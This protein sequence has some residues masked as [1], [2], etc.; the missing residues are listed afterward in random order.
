[1]KLKRNIKN[2]DKFRE[3]IRSS[4]HLEPKNISNL[5]KLVKKKINRLKLTQN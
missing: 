3:I 5:I 1:M 2:L 4:T